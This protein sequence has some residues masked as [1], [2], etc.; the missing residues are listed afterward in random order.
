M[1]L[2]KGQDVVIESFEVYLL[3][4]DTTFLLLSND[5]KVYYLNEYSIRV[6]NDKHRIFIPKRDDEALY[7]HVY[8]D[9]KSY[10]KAFGGTDF[11]FF[12]PLRKYYYID[13][14]LDVIIRTSRSKKSLCPPSRRRVLKPSPH[15]AVGVS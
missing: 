9:K 2:I 11:G 10:K 5:F 8:L 12:N 7:L 15:L 13:L 3:G 6:C 14:G 4:N 1:K